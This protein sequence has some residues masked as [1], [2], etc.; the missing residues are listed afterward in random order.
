M[1]ILSSTSVRPRYAS[2]SI[3]V[4]KGKG[5]GEQEKYPAYNYT[6]L[7]D[8][9]GFCYEPRVKQGPADRAALSKPTLHPS[10]KMSQLSSLT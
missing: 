8:F 4:N 9:A 10:E 5:E 3:P 1:A 7:S 2:E 6:R